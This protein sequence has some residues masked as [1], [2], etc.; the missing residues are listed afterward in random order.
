MQFILFTGLRTLTGPVFRSRRHIYLPIE[1][2]S[3]DGLYYHLSV[4]GASIFWHGN[5]VV[6]E[7]MYIIR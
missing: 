4:D 3:V 2:C 1:V 7:F 6:Y 5:S